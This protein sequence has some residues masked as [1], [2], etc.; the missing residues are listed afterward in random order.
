MPAFD[1]PN[2]GTQGQEVTNP[3]TGI[4]YTYNNGVWEVTGS[5]VAD[6][7]ATQEELTAEANA[8]ALA[9]SGLDGRI[10]A[11]ENTGAYD[12]TPIYAALETESRTRQLADENLQSQI[13]GIDVDD[14]DLSDYYTK[15]EV[16]VITNELQNQIND[17]A[18]T[19]GAG[20]VYTLN[21]IGIT[22]GIRPGDFY[23]DNTIA[24]NVKFMTLS[25]TDDNDNNRPLG[26]EG[27][28][29]EL[30][31]LN[32]RS[33]RYEI[34][35][36][37]DG[38]AGVDFL[39]ADD[40]DDLLIPGTTFQVYIYPQNKETASIDYVDTAV[41]GLA[42]VQYVNDE[43]DKLATSFSLEAS[44]PDVIYSDDVP[45]GTRKNGDM[46]FDSMKLRLNV[47]SQG[48]WV[49]PDRN[50]GKDLENRITELEARIAQL[51]GN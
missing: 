10:T 8:R 33:Y 19:K 48:A 9:D 46:W 23:I 1:F 29:I 5:S 47:W 17:L 38:V 39:V 40:P 37:G 28:I 7:Y 44:E 25:P 18:V 42:N 13:D 6:G 2:P 34:T 4:T 32:N 45:Q 50:D 15:D 22:V 41:A 30:I 24:K 43:V 35:T 16:D 14:I 49:N 31:G 36:S 51:E 12:P 11:I 26:S 27:D 21:D 20:A 3:T